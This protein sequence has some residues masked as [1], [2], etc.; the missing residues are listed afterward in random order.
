MDRVEQLRTNIGKV[1]FFFN[2]EKNQSA[3][4]AHYL[5]KMIALKR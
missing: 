1:G 4:Y 5:I 2:D 3:K